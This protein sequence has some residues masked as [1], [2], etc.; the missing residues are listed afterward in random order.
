MDSNVSPS[1]KWPRRIRNGAV[2]VAVAVAVY[3][4]LG[5][6]VLPLAVKPKLE[7]RLTQQLGRQATLRRLE[8]NPF[9]LRAR[10]LD[11]AVTDRDRG[12][13]FVRFERLDLDVAPASLIYL[14]P[15]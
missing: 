3:A 9:T 5:F 1:S 6:L 4:L 8:F 15:V 10:A 11:F 12:R 14:A 13:P 7:A 2:A